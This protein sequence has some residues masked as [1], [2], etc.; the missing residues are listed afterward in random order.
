MSRLI[1]PGLHQSYH[2]LNTSDSFSIIKAKPIN[3]A[4]FS[5]QNPAKIPDKAS[6][7]CDT[8]YYQKEPAMKTPKTTQSDFKGFR[9][10]YSS[11]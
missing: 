5:W 4:F 3:A 11:R 9:E 10:Q 1:L 2:N 7:G 6:P 8:L